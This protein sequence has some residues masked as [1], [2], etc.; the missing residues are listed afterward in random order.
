MRKLAAFGLLL[1]LAL[2]TSQDVEDEGEKLLD[3]PCTAPETVR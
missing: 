3:T 2:A 1:L